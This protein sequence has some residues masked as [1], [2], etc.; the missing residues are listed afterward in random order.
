MSDH[1]AAVFLSYASQDAA[2]AKHI[3]ES[4]RASGVEVWFDVE[5]GLE[6]G[7]EWDAKIRR[8]IKECVLFIAVI[9][10]NTQA[11]E[12]GYFRLEWDLAAER[13][14]TI[15]SGVA[16]ILPVVIDATRE[17]EALVPDR[18]RTVQWT[19]LPGG[20][21]PPEVQARFL[22]LWSHRTG[23]LKHDAA[24][25][26]NPGAGLAEAGAES[27]TRSIKR[28]P[29][30]VPALVGLVAVIALLL[31]HPWRSPDSDLLAP[32]ASLPATVP[33]SEARQL[34]AQ[35]WAQMNRLGLARAELQAADEL[36]RRASVLDPTNPDV[37][38]AWS[39]VDAWY[40]YH[41]FD[42]TPER[43]EGARS[44]AARA[45]NLAPSSYEA[46]LAQAN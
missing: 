13:V 2:A 31:W 5:G 45:L 3:A 43:R 25:T 24:R 35:A 23:V 19:K 20:V 11:R 6:H 28:R 34:V 29:W 14:R 27:A 46:R 26:E 32:R 38:A 22:K 1:P 9:S 17:P 33:T 42:N 18:F 40:C 7:D 30:L 12:E 37:W 15:A 16:F 4:L 41:A 21:V 44:K 10:A 39:F 36:C 8:Q